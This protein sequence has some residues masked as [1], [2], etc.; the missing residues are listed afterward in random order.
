[1]TRHPKP[2][3]AV[4]V[5]LTARNVTR[6]W[7][8][9]AVS[10]F[11]LLVL[12]GVT[13]SSLGI[14]TMRQEPSSPQGS[15]IGAP[16]PIRSDEY[17]TSS[18]RSIG[19]A[20][21]ETSDDLNPLT[22]PDQISTGLPGGPASTAIM[23]DG[24]LMGLPIVPDQM[25]FA[26]RWWLPMLLLALSS[27]V[28][29]R[30]ITGSRYIGMFAATLIMFSP[31]TAWWSFQPVTIL[32]Y[33][34]AGCAALMKGATQ[35]AS[36]RSWL[37]TA[38]LI[39][40]SILLARTPLHYQPWAIVLSL[41]VL[42]ATSATVIIR[43]RRSG[44]IALAVVAVGSLGLFGLVV[45]DNLDGLS[46]ILQTVYP[47]QRVATG[48]PQGV[49]EVFGAIHLGSLEHVAVQGTNQ[50]E[51]SSSF[52][53]LAVW[54]VVLLAGGAR[55]LDGALKAATI[56]LFSATAFWFAWVQVDFGDLG[57]RIPMVNRVPPQRAA[58]VVGYLAVLL[59]CM[60]VTSWRTNGW[61][62]PILAGLAVWMVSAY[63]GSVLRYKMPGLSVSSVWVASSVL[64]LI[65]IAITRSPRWWLGYAAAVTAAVSLVYS[66]NPII[67][68]LGDLR[69]SS[70]AQMM[71][72][73]GREARSGGH[74]W[75]SD[76]L[77]VDSL[78][79]SAGVPSLSGR[80]LTGPVGD[81]WR[82]LVPS[83]TDE[84][85]WNRGGSFIWF[86]WTKEDT[87]SVTNPSP[88]AILISGSPCVVARAFKD[89][90]TV[91]STSRL[92]ES[93][94]ALQSSFQWSGNTNWVYRV[95]AR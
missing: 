57:Y 23:F 63:A 16:L 73:E 39:V 9:A 25:L 75:V 42:A 14:D 28:F 43:E 90:S 1:M 34:L 87:I 91:V 33:T 93:C 65:V 19:R 10:I 41:P 81:A 62:V 21:T 30:V 51:I 12:T 7:N 54:A 13:Q 53:I 4:A 76:N 17:L 8:G 94:L 44:L 29:F 46:T 69:D 48:A 52:A 49:D 61:R 84:A 71:L 24:A 27:P 83:G 95:S 15:M 82:R 26:A 45:L 55:L 35:L 67:V 2:V 70:T 6:L 36:Q 74:L 79:A 37:A 38:W 22:A 11:V 59:L 89:L 47:G 18:A 64:T 56:I 72:T 58:D 20:A 78:M 85:S 92:T 3:D 86:R 32:G 40:A 80:Q 88:D 31:A 5:W 77:Y 68:G 60:V 66:V 50:S